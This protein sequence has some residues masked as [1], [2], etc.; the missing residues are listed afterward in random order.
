[1]WLFEQPLVILFSG[2][3]ALAIAS[4][5]WLQTR[6]PAALMVLIATLATTAAGLL[7]ERLVVT[8]AEQ[9][10]SL[11]HRIAKQMERNEVADVVAQISESA[12]GLRAEVQDVLSRVTVEKVSIKRNL[13]VKVVHRT[14]KK[15]AEA[16][17]NAVATVQDRRGMLG[18]HIV[19]RYL[20]VR[21]RY[22]ADG[23]KVTDYEAFDPR[24]GM[25]ANP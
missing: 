10:Q 20:V 15:S 25:R 9:V 4:A 5:V 2:A 1:M 3:L 14:G 7:V 12:A 18:T 19:P 16:R 13:R 24:E 22:E 11:L 17:F 6:R 8:D 21:F 23:W